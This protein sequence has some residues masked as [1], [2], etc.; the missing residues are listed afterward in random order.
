MIKPVKFTSRQSP[1]I[2]TKFK[3]VT[4]SKNIIGDEFV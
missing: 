4:T 3:T 1:V 2:P